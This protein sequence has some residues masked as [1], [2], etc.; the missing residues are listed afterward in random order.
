LTAVEARTG[1]TQWNVGLA[2]LGGYQPVAGAAADGH[3]YL[4]WRSQSGALRLL[5]ASTKDGATQ[6]ERAVAC[7]T[8]CPEASIA[9]S[10]THAVIA[11]RE[12]KATQLYLSIT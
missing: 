4:L 3:A 9:A 5:T 10:G 2:G 12:E 1:A 6:E 7:M 11:T 8:R